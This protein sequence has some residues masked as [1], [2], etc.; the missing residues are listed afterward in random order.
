[1]N[2]DYNVKRKFDYRLPL[3]SVTTVFSPS[4][5]LSPP[6]LVAKAYLLMGCIGFVLITMSLMEKYFA[7]NGFYQF[8]SQ[9]LKFV[10]IVMPFALIAALILF[11][12]L[13][14]LL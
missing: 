13:N 10:K 12:Y 4:S 7:I 8:A 1:M 6:P 14:P 9:L 11:V 3:L 5:L 2:N